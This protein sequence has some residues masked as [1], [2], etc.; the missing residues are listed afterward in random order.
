MTVQAS[1]YLML[2]LLVYVVGLALIKS[3]VCVT[4]LR[5]A[6]ANQTYKIATLSLLSLTLMTF[7]AT[8]VGVLL[9]CRPIS[10]N[11][12]GKGQCTGMS[13]M[14]AL[15]YFSTASTIL[16]DLSLAILP[17]VM[18]WGT[19]MNVRQKIL[20]VALLSFGSM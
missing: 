12:T 11:W 8:F 4:L 2:W 10:G 6:A 15:S 7:V 5:V 16:T 9:L 1:K 19:P 14:V 13:T 17:G 3:S 20:I 18:V